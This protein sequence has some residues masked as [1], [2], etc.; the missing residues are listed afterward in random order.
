MKRGIFE[1]RVTKAYGSSV[2]YFH[3]FLT[4]ALDRSMLQLHARLINPRGNSFLPPPFE[5]EAYKH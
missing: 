1:L 5:Q 4:S 2:L 3:L